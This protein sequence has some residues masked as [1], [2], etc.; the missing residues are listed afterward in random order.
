LNNVNLYGPADDLIQAVR[1][2]FFVVFVQTQALRGV[3]L[4]GQ[5]R[6]LLMGL[7]AAT[8]TGCFGAKE[9]PQPPTP[10]KIEL[11]IEAAGDVNPN[12]QGKGSPVL[13]RVYELKGLAAFNAADYFALSEK[14]QTALGADLARKQ[15]LM[16]RPG[17]KKTLMLQP[18]DAASYIAAYAGFRSLNAARWRVSAPIPAH[19]SSVFELKLVGTQMSLTTPPAPQPA[20]SDSKPAA[21]D[22]KR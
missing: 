12:A 14:D 2:I 22:A 9:E 17:E 13:L 19:A 1:P 21:E 20:D 18:E 8:L 5:R 11:R 4:M 6:S 3:N 15:E 10:T 16:L 7:I